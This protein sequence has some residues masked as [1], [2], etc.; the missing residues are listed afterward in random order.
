MSRSLRDQLIG[1]WH[2]VRYI[3]RP[4][5]GSPERQPLGEYPLGLILYTPDGYMSAQLSAPDRQP[6]ASG[7]WFVGTP[8]EFEVEASTYIAYSGAFAI[9]TT[10]GTLI[11]GMDVSLFPN[12]CG[13]RQV[14]KVTLDGDRLVLAS[15]A[16]LLS[17][18]V[19]IDAEL[20]WQRAVPATEGAAIVTADAA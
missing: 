12:W 14:R 10:P 20:H 5:D 6:F 1:A 8:D 17:G 16:P 11:H 15:D 13:Q 9:G 19:L 2:L 3:E 4:I 7:D 18:G